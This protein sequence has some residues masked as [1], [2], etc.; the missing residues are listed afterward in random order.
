MKGGKKEKEKQCFHFNACVY[1]KQLRTVSYWN[2]L[3]TTL[4]LENNIMAFAY[5]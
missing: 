2:C 3:N 4:F 1:R 5:F